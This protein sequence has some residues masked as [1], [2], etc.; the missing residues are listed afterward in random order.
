MTGPI[1][2]RWTATDPTS[3]PPGGGSPPTTGSGATRPNW[4]LRTAPGPRLRTATA[5]GPGRWIV[6][7][8]ACGGLLLVGGLVLAA[9]WARRRPGPPTRDN[10]ASTRGPRRTDHRAATVPGHLHRRGVEGGG[11]GPALARG[12]PDGPCRRD[13]AG[14]GDRHRNGGLAVTTASLVEGATSISSVDP[15]TGAP[16]PAQVVAGD[17]GSNLAVVRVAGDPPVATFD[18][19][20]VTDRTDH[21]G[22]GPGSVA[23]PREGSGDRCLRRCGARYRYRGERRRRH[24]GA[25]RHHGRH[26]GRRGGCRLPVLDAGAT[27][28]A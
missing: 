16:D 5:P 8:A 4:T 3:G 15:A 20:A 19:S 18:D 1:R 21:G 17:P 11:G 10:H 9:R 2:P 25:R 12:P 13:R 22:G 27:S 6:P 14:D 24:H 7:V 26:A 23:R 28:S